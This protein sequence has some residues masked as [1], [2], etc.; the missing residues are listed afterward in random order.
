MTDTMTEQER[1][2]MREHRE[3]AARI[4]EDLDRQ[5]EWSDA[6]GRRLDIIT[7]VREQL[8]EDLEDGLITEET[9]R[10]RTNWSRAQGRYYIDRHADGDGDENDV[11]LPDLESCN[12]P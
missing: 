5:S 3:W 10:W 6:L 8:D 7:E 4:G 1:T 9:W 12:Y 11:E 2:E